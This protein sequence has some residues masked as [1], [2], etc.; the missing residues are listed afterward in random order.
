ML[1]ALVSVFP[2]G[3]FDAEVLFVFA[4]GTMS[5]VLETESLKLFRL[6]LS[7]VS[8]VDLDSELESRE[9]DSL[10]FV[11]D[12]LGLLLLRDATELG[13][14]YMLHTEGFAEVDGFGGGLKEGSF[15]GGG[16]EVGGGLTVG[17]TGTIGFSVSVDGT[18]GQ[19]RFSNLTTDPGRS[20]E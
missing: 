4:L 5:L 20:S 19:T 3:S 1:S 12:M 11:V 17:F 14:A 7:G 8:A 9:F 10:G 18:G 15:G 13:A 6:A 2:P 16:F